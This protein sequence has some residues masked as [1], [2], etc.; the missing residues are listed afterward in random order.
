MSI[1]GKQVSSV[2]KQAARAIAV[3]GRCFTEAASPL[4]G[5][6]A[7]ASD[8]GRLLLIFADLSEILEKSKRILSPYDAHMASFHL[9]L[10]QQEFLKP[11]TDGEPSADIIMMAGTWLQ[12]RVPALGPALVQLWLTSAAAGVISRA[13]YSL[14]FWVNARLSNYEVEGGWLNLKGLSET[15]QEYASED[16]LFKM[17]HVLHLQADKVYGKTPTEKVQEILAVCVRHGRLPELHAFL[18]NQRKEQEA[19]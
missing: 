7:P 19:N 18:N 4:N 12:R 2:K 1:N 9:D 17:C 6:K 13:G 5:A 15:L 8:Q 16:F 14:S 3:D 10:L 11:R